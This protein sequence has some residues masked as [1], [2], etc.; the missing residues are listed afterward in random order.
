MT[1]FRWY[2]DTEPASDLLADTDSP[3]DGVQRLVFRPVPVEESAANARR[4]AEA[5]AGTSTSTSV[6]SSLK[7]KR[8]LFRSLNAP[9]A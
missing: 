5:N 8:S 4:A 6:S 9:M 2:R 3:A 7:S 1:D